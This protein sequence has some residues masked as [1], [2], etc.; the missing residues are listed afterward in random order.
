MYFLLKFY[1]KAQHYIFLP[2]NSSG[3]DA[4]YQYWYMKLDNWTY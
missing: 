2:C 4:R 3:L 1:P